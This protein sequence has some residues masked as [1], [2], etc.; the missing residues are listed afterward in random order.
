MAVSRLSKFFGSHLILAS[1]E[2][3]T[4][5]SAIHFIPKSRCTQLNKNKIVLKIKISILFLVCCIQLQAQKNIFC[6][7]PYI[8]IVNQDYSVEQLLSDL[9]WETLKIFCDTTEGHYAYVTNEVNTTT[10]RY[11]K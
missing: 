11:V 4:P 9:Q 5:R 6:K 1:V 3:E 2:S 8:E 10:Y 7:F